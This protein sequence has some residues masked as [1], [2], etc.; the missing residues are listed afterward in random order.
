VTLVG[1]T[2]GG[3]QITAIEAVPHAYQTA[4]DT[5]IAVPPV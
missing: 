5:A 1:A 3:W 4:P 2:G